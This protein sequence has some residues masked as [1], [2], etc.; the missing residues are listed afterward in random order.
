LLTVAR[1]NRRW[2]PHKLL[3]AHKTNTLPR[4]L[5]RGS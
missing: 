3:S 4:C 2:L 5:A 1:L